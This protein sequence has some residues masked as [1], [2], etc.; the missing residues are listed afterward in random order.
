M[1]FSYTVK[2]EKN[3]DTV[4]SSLTEDLKDIG[5]GVLDTLDFK[6]ILADKGLEFSENYNS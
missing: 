6:K 1:G 4:I 2:T 5:F 3:I